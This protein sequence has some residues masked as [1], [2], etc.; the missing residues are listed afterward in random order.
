[1]NIKT[2]R[3]LAFFLAGIDAGRIFKVHD[4]CRTPTEIYLEK[5]GSDDQIII[6]LHDGSIHFETVLDDDDQWPDDLRAKA[7]A[8]MLSEALQ[9]ANRAYKW[10]AEHKTK[11]ADGGAE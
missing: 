5:Y 1:M 8:G 11:R 9:S 3:E 10:H 2:T 4:G 7:L 6:S